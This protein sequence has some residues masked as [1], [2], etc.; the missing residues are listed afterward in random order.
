MAQELLQS[1]RK[2]IVMISM[3]LVLFSMYTTNDTSK[4]YS[5]SAHSILKISIY[6]H[7][8]PFNAITTNLLR[9]STFF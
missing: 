9:N 5:C 4:S 8:N 2:L 1:Y 6:G 7:N 3:I